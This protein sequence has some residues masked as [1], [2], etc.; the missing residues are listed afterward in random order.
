MFD[1]HTLTIRNVNEVRKMLRSKS[2]RCKC[3]V[4]TNLTEDDIVRDN[5]NYLR[6]VHYALAVNNL[7]L[8]LEDWI[9]KRKI[10]SAREKIKDSAISNL[11]QVLPLET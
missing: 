9:I 8:E 11:K 6:R 7:L 2:W 1:I 3:Q 5:W 10:E 4:C